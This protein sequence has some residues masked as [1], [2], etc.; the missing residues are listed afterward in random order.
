MTGIDELIERAKEG[1]N[2]P[3]T[4]SV[5]VALAPDRASAR[6][7]AIARL[8]ERFSSGGALDVFVR[9]DGG[10]W[11]RHS[12]SPEGHEVDTERILWVPY[13]HGGQTFLQACYY[14]DLEPQRVEA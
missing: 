4:Y 11:D 2:S 3:A 6:D 9:T 14:L 13:R 12:W 10:S 8:R 1:L 7:A 5:E